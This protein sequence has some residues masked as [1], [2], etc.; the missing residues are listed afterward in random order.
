MGTHIHAFIEVDYATVGQ[1]FGETAEVR[2]FNRGEFFIRNVYEL[3]DALGDGRSRHFPPEAVGRQATFPPR[4]LPSNPSYGVVARYAHPIVEPN[5]VEARGRDS[6]PW[7]ALRSVTPE[8]AER[9][10]AQGWSHYYTPESR[11]SSGGIEPAWVSNPEWRPASW[12]LLPEVYR[13]LADFGLKVN[14][15]S[16][17]VE[18]VLRVPRS[19]VAKY[20]G[21]SS[22]SVSAQ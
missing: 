1:P 14:E 21:T 6:E 7:P 15:L 5:A 3:F 8:E 12:L 19:G 13:A 20:H 16:P 11:W 4:G 17:E 2:C 9:W 10:V 22:P 18:A